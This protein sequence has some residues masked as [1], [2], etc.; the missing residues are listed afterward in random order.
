M[1]LTSPHEA[2]L[3][4]LKVDAEFHGRDIGKQLLEVLETRARQRGFQRLADRSQS[5]SNY[6]LT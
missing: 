2:V 6:F 4:R 1:S 3:M 5:Y